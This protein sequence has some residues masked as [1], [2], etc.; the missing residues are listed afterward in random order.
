MGLDRERSADAVGGA[1]DLDQ[2]AGDLFQQLVAG[3]VAQRVIDPLEAIEIEEQQCQRSVATLSM[4]DGETELI[5]EGASVG[6][7]GQHI[8]VGQQTNLLLGVLALGDVLYGALKAHLLAAV[9][10][11]HLGLLHDVLL[12]PVDLPVRQNS[13]E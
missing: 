11:E 5:E 6:Q 13:V 12:C 3:R 4:V 7:S 2:A 10:E 9:V 1:H 8:V